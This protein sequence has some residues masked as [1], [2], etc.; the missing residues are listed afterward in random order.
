M[1]D[2]TPYPGVGAVE[3]ID[4]LELLVGK[5]TGYWAQIEDQLFNIFVAV[6][7]RG[8]PDANDIAPYRAVFF[9]FS[10][11]EAKMRLVNNAIKQR[12]ETGDS[13]LNEWDGLRKKLNKFSDLRNEIAHLV[14]TVRGL[15]DRTT[16]AVARLVPPFWKAYPQTSFDDAGYSWQELTDAL[17]PFWGFNPALGR[18]G[19]GADDRRGTA[20]F[21]S[22]TFAANHSL[23]S[24]INS[25][26]TSR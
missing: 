21:Q 5:I 18:L 25:L 4:K 13:I 14:A 12:Y 6:L 8:Y 10:S 3:E 7:A 2:K 17:K 23:S 20:A 26:N 19:G 24:T 11:Y 1:T 16:T 15:E 9:T 22:E